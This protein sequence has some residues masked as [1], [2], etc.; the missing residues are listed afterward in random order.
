MKKLLLPL[1]LI[2]SI[3][4]LAQDEP[5]FLES[6]ISN[7]NDH[8]KDIHLQLINM[9]NSLDNYIDG[10]PIDIKEYSSA[11]G[12]IQLSAYQN[13]HENISFDQKVKI[14]LTVL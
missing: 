10:P 6:I 1:I 9:S 13:Q 2:N 12:L 4:V 5:S 8:R 7:T 14:K 11:Y 3:N